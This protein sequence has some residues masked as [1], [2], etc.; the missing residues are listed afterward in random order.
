MSRPLACFS[1]ALARACTART[2]A[3]PTS[4]TTS[5]AAAAVTAVRCR[6]IHR[7]ARSASGSRQAE[8]GSSAI[9]RSTSSASA[10]GE[11]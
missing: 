11:A 3:S 1:S 7:R 5:A 4:A 2:A 10:R 9:H 6:R 8:T